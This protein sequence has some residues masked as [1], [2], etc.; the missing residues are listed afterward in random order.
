MNTP[1]TPAPASRATYV[2]LALLVA[3]AAALYAHAASLHAVSV[4]EAVF[5]RASLEIL[6]GD[7]SLSGWRVMKPPVVYYAQ[8]LSRGLLG[9]T[10]FAGRVP[11]LLASLGILLLMFRVVRR[12]LDAPTALLT[13]AL[14][15]AAPYAVKHLPTGRTDALALFFI[16]LSIDLVGRG[17]LWGGGFAYG[18]SFA[19]RQLAALSFPLV[20]AFA[21]LA[22]HLANEDATPPRKFAWRTIWRFFLG[23]L[24]VL[25]VVFVWSLFEKIPF[26]WLVNEIQGKKYAE[27]AHLQVGFVTKLQY[28]LTG[29]AD[30]FVF[31]A[32]GLIAVGG[33]VAGLWLVVTRLRGRWTARQ[34]P[35]NAV[36]AMVAVFAA[37]FLLAHCLRF[38]TMYERFLVPLLPWAALLVAWPL[39]RLVDKLGRGRTWPAVALAGL[40]A[41]S[42][43]GPMAV[44]SVGARDMSPLHRPLP[45]D[46]VGPAVRWVE[47]NARPG[48]LIYNRKLGPEFDY[49]TF[50]TSVKHKQLV[51][52]PEK[53]KPYALTKLGR[54]MFLFLGNKH[55]PA[56]RKVLDAELP[57]V[58]ALEQVDAGLLQSRLYRLVVTE[59]G[60]LEGGKIA[61]LDGDRIVREELT[62]ASLGRRLQRGVIAPDDDSADAAFVWQ[63]CDP[64]PEPGI[65]AWQMG[66]FQLGKLR[67]TKAAFY[68]ERPRLDW[69]ALTLAHRLVVRET[70]SAHAEFLIEGDELARY[71]Q[72]KNRNLS[73][74][75]V[76][77]VG[78]ELRV[79]ATAA[80]PIWQ[81]EVEVTGSLTLAENQVRFVLS[82]AKVAGRAVPAFV[83]GYAEKLMNPAFTVD[84][85][86]WGLAPTEM[87]LAAPPAN[88]IVLI[89]R[90][91]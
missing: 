48:A 28:W 1:H 90:Q 71:I 78:A 57:P 33:L 39:A 58:F 83:R 73:D 52:E 12:W 69:S 53:L 31:S 11:G 88:A 7:W 26:A 62:C 3:A 41:G 34:N 42:F 72:R 9:E 82:E 20:I 65:L 49:A 70:H 44:V 46:D 14:M 91:R 27:G 5:G 17:R 29:A 60:G 81:P 40:L 4:D 77:P 37:F 66:D 74:I 45:E 23:T 84:L 24:P 76:R 25:A 2:C 13:V 47:Q 63:V 19:S 43:V 55:D 38:L 50:G 30:F 59:R 18:L 64:T 10:A 79:T 67:V 16:L 61:W 6:H 87:R 8:A 80:L 68:F 89:A 36:L 22:A 15:V 85:R 86:G 35:G 21:L 51:Y 56:W 75:R 54:D 32:L